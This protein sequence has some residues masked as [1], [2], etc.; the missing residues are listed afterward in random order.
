MLREIYKAVHT[1]EGENMIGYG[2]RDKF[3]G[4]EYINNYKKPCLVI[5]NG[6]VYEEIASFNNA[7]AAR[8]FLDFLAEIY[9]FEKVDWNGAD[10]PIG[11]LKDSDSWI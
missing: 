6:N 10:I 2:N 8:K 7:E 5:K 9:G 3:Y 1:A 4:V 11:L